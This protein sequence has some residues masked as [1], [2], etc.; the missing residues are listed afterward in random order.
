MLWC[1]ILKL[2]SAVTSFP[3]LLEKHCFRFVFFSFIYSVQLFSHC[4][5]CS[6]KVN[7][8]QKVK[9]QIFFFFFWK[10]FHS[11]SGLRK[12]WNLSLGEWTRIGCLP[13]WWF[14]NHTI[15]TYEGVKILLPI[16]ISTIKVLFLSLVSPRLQTTTVG[17]WGSIL[18]GH[19]DEVEAKLEKFRKLAY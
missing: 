9:F 16:D 13:K 11:W 17:L 12:G 10:E 15:L 14:S 6:R 19:F 8:G 5:P 7:V 2:P 3:F 18:D 4:P 1:C